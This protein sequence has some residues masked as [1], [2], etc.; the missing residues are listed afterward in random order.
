MIDLKNPQSLASPCPMPF[1]RADEIIEQWRF[2]LG[3]ELTQSKRKSDPRFPIDYPHE[4]DSCD[5]IPGAL[6]TATLLPVP[7]GNR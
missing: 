3:R 7:H 6:F 1:A 5:L 2:L 4:L